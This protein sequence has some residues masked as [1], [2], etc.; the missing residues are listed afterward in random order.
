MLTLWKRVGGTYINLGDWTIPNVGT[1]WHTIEIRVKG[2]DL[3]VYHDETYYSSASLGAGELTSGKVGIFSS[4]G[5]YGH[6][7]DYLV[8][9]YVSLEPSTALGS[10]ERNELEMLI[11]A[12]V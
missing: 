5:T 1:S 7:D 6:W 8:R 2:Q 9:E 12:D 10:E 4:Y 3:Y 11:H